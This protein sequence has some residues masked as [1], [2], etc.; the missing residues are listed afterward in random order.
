M[1][2]YPDGYVPHVGEV[3]PPRAL[4]WVPQT[5]EDIP[6]R[7]ETARPEFLGKRAVPDANIIVP[8]LPMVILNASSSRIL[9]LSLGEW[10]EPPWRDAAPE[11]RFVSELT[12]EPWWGMT[13][14]GSDLLSAFMEEWRGVS[15]DLAAQGRIVVHVRALLARHLQLGL[16]GRKR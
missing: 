5:V 14:D 2:T 10:T 6:G 4:V 7:W 16:L 3:I 12:L 15:L 11:L 9:M 1:T 13:E 8:D